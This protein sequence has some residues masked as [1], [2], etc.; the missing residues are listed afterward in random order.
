MTENIFDAVTEIYHSDKA[1]TSIDFESPNIKD[2]FEKIANNETARSFLRNAAH[3]IE[4]M[5]LR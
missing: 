5:I 4:K 2:G 1:N 3:K